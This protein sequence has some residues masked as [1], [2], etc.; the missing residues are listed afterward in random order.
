MRLLYPVN[1]DRPNAHALELAEKRPRAES[2]N[3]ANWLIC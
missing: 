1:R 2:L 3:P